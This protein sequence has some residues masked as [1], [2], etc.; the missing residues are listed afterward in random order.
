MKRRV[1]LVLRALLVLVVV[2]AG[3]LLISSIIVEEIHSPK[4]GH[5]RASRHTGGQTLSTKP[6]AAGLAPPRTPP[7][8]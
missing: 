6:R 4:S 8:A 2:A 7:E 5:S 1:R 3:A